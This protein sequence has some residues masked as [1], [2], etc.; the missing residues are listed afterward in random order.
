MRWMSEDQL[1]EEEAGHGHGSRSE[2]QTS[3]GG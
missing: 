2:L 3:I 1:T